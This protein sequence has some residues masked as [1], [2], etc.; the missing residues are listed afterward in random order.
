MVANYEHITKMV[1]APIENL[2]EIAKL[3]GYS[4]V[5]REAKVCQQ[6]VSKWASGAKIRCSTDRVI[7]DTVSKI[8]SRVVTLMSSPLTDSVL[9]NG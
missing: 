4:Y 9:S 3:L 6:S 7:T 1:N 5:A 2:R 8:G